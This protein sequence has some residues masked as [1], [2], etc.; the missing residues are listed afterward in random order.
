MT[1]FWELILFF[2]FGA[3][4]NSILTFIYYA[5][6]KKCAKRYIH[7]RETTNSFTTNGEKINVRNHPEFWDA[8][9]DKQIREKEKLKR[10][11]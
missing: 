7:L 11:K 6:M 8:I 2:M 5:E 9:L 1:G 4:T 10:G 3:I